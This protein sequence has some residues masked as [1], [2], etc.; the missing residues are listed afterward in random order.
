MLDIPSNV[1]FG[2]PKEKSSPIKAKVPD[3]D[4]KDPE[5]ISNNLKA[6]KVTVL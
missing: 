5:N 2:N 3:V 1:N 4:I 6:N